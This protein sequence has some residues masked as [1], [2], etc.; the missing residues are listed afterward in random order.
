MLIDSNAV[1]GITG[2]HFNTF[3]F[4]LSRR[5]DYCEK[6]IISFKKVQLNTELYKL[7]TYNTDSE[8]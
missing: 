6:K 1:T 7:T 2:Q 4:M 3:F 8:H 5:F